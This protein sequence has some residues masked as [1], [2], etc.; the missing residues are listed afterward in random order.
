MKSEGLPIRTYTYVADVV[1]AIFKVLLDSKEVVY[2]ISDEDSKVSIKELAELLVNLYKDRGIKLVT[3]IDNSNEKGNASFTLGILS[4][5]KIRE[6]LK[7][8]PNYSLSDGFKRTV[9]YLESDN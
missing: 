5:K 3:T 8:K 4:S 9:D 1:S 6:E 2:N 7:W